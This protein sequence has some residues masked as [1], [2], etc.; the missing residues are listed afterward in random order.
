MTNACAVHCR[1]VVCVIR[2]LQHLPGRVQSATGLVVV[3]AKYQAIAFKPFR[4]EVKSIGSS[5]L[6]LLIRM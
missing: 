4:E 3:A 6:R 1:Y 2:L 5:L